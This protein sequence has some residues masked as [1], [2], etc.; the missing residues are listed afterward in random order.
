MF[1]KMTIGMFLYLIIT[2]LS[3]NVFSSRICKLNRQFYLKDKFSP[4]FDEKT[5]KVFHN[6]KLFNKIQ[7]SFFAQIGS[8]PK[9]TEDEDYHWFDGDGMI[10]GIYFNNSMLTYQNRWIQTKRFQIENKWNKKMYLYFG[11]LKGLKGLY[12]IIKYTTMEILGFIP[13]AKG[14]ANTALLNWNNRIFA[15]H[16]GDMP[17]ELEINYS[18]LNISTKSRFEHPSIYSTTAHPIIDKY[19]DLL[20]LYG[21]NNYDFS[22]GNFIFNVFDKNMNLLNQ[23]NISLINNGM[24]HDVAFTGSEIIIPD[25]PLKYDVSR[26]LKEQLPLYF[27]KENGKT[28]FGVY[29]I[30][31]KSEPRWFDF[32][33]NFFIFHFSKA[34][35]GLNKY[36]IFACVMD[37][38]FMEDFVDLDNMHNEEH[39]IRG[40][41]RLKAIE[42]NE[43][44]N[45]TRIIENGF[46][47]NLNL[48][49]QYNLDFPIVS[50]LNSDYIY[51]T[52]FDSAMGYI[53]GFL[54]I[55]TNNFSISMP[56]VYLFEKGKY[57]NSEPQ[58]VVI[59]NKEYLITF[60]NDDNKSYI[61]LIDIENGKLEE[62]VIPTRIPP[63]FHSIYY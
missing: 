61:S 28:R 9:Y 2:S 40:N 17:Y 8:N 24:T 37:N 39:V 23:K 54:K 29:N 5:I 33:E 18:D 59:D 16:E 10:H 47:E 62:I 1:I 3:F 45:E 41:I 57:A 25:M 52:I 49:F 51:C 53:K 60:T 15:L 7:N 19:K 46:L 56:K 12:Q 22:Y 30:N 14:T 20:Y 6:N 31:M 38:L 35:K 36:L 26:I 27:D 63:G 42:L 48:D 21:Y 50:K 44:T 32:D 58:I 43:K 34:Y 4:V 11:E 13:Q 55:S